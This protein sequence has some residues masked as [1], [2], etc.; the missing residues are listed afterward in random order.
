MGMLR[1][2]G[3]T[4]IPLQGYAAADRQVALLQG[5]IGY[6]QRI[7]SGQAG[8][9]EPGEGETDPG[10]PTQAHGGGGSPVKGLRSP[11]FR[12]RRLLLGAGD[13]TPRQAWQG[14]D[15]VVTPP[16]FL[17]PTAQMFTE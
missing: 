13:P 17:D 12:Q 15:R 6:I 10:A 7:A 3:G 5:Y 11:P 2:A 8:K 4:P 16:R 1:H 9:L 14:P